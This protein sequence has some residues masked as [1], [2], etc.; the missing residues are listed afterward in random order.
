MDLRPQTELLLYIDVDQRCSKTLMLQQDKALGTD[1][2][3]CTEDNKD[4]FIIY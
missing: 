1:T 3:F 2:L 4:N